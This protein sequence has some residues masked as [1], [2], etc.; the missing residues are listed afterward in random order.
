MSFS[1]SIS[2]SISNVSVYS[3]FRDW[4]LGITSGEAFQNSYLR[5]QVGNCLVSSHSF[6]LVSVNLC[7]LFYSSCLLWIRYYLL[8]TC[9]YLLYLILFY[10]PNI[11]PFH[12]YL[13]F[14]DFF[15]FLYPIIL[16]SCILLMLLFLHL[17]LFFL[18][19]Y[20]IG[21]IFCLGNENQLAILKEMMQRR[22]INARISGT[23]R[24]C[25]FS[26][27][28]GVGTINLLSFTFLCPSV[29]QFPYFPVL[30]KRE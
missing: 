10:F 26:F 16:L 15:Y 4:I 21:F 2:I 22:V 5:F 6:P 19:F 13:L 7:F 14:L 23:N 27:T 3:S 25:L 24:R 20:Y 8:F 17:L 30:E 29:L 9:L 18:Y 11:F 1:S 28:L 12:L